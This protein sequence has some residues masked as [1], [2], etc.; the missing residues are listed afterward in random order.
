MLPNPSRLIATRSEALPL[1]VRTSEVP[2]FV[3]D[4]ARDDVAPIIVLKL[5]RVRG[6]EVDAAIDG[7]RA[8]VGHLA[9][10]TDANVAGYRD[11]R[12]LERVVASPS[13]RRA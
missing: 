2:L 4:P 11:I 9:H 12:H 8:A 13:K 5:P 6:R 10:A 7:G 3:K 1:M